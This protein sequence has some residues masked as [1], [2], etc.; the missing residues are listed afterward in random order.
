MR[1]SGS[2]NDVE[3]ETK[4]SNNI[5][6]YM[7]EKQSNLQNGPI[8]K[9]QIPGLE[10]VVFVK[11]SG[12]HAIDYGYMPDKPPKEV[13]VSRK[14]AEAV[15]RGAQVQRASSLLMCNL[16]AVYFSSFYLLLNFEVMGFFI[17]C[18]KAL[19]FLLCTLVKFEV[20]L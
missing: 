20:S 3:D 7:D 15:L 12:P 19:Q 8:S 14:C 4:A 11:G 10:Y 17:L 1:N 5:D 18:M 16:R 2:K 9:C 6:S 13:L